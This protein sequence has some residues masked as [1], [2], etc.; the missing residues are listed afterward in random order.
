MY[1]THT[2]SNLSH[3]KI[4]QFTNICLFKTNF[5]WCLNSLATKTKQ[6]HSKISTP[7]RP[8]GILLS[9]LTIFILWPIITQKIQ[10]IDIYTFSFVYVYNF[11]FLVESLFEY[12]FINFYEYGQGTTAICN[13][14]LQKD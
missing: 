13:N 3:S 7:S 14:R 2:E 1:L 5:R 11:P 6:F 10:F 9:K 8:K 4:I 12:F